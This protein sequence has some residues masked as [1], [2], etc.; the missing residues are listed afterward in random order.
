VVI[1]QSQAFVGGLDL[2]YGRYDTEQHLIDDDNKFMYPGIEYNNCRIAD[3][4]DVKHYW[5]ENV[6]RTL[7]RLPW[8]DVCLMV[9]GLCVKDLSRH[10]I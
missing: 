9:K 7:P 8:H 3:F 6:P 5:K 4:T 10:F 2:C 1:D